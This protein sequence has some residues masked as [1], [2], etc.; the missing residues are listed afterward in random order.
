M[1]HCCVSLATYNRNQVVSIDIRILM[2]YII[3]QY[4]I[5]KLFVLECVHSQRFSLVWCCCCRRRRSGVF[6]VLCRS[7]SCYCSLCCSICVWLAVFTASVLIALLLVLVQ[8]NV[9]WTVSNG[10]GGGAAFYY[11]FYSVLVSCL[12]VDAFAPFLITYV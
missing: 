6:I 12:S 8:L 11:V 4:S 9:F 10:R 5:L 1:C 2:S 3:C 7:C